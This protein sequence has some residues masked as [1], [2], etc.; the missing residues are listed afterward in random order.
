MISPSEQ[1]VL[2]IAVSITGIFRK[3]TYGLLGTYDGTPNNDLRNKNGSIVSSNA[4]LER[5]HNDFGMTW[6]I[7][8]S[9]SMFYY[10]S[11]QSA[12]FFQEQNRVFVPSFVDPTAEN[13]STI[14][15]VCEINATS[16]P[17]S[18]TVPGGPKVRK[19]SIFFGFYLI[20]RRLGLIFIPH[21]L[22]DISKRC[23]I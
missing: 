6:S 10:E 14:L 15:N 18:W 8:P 20:D 13:N 17:S 12:L 21:M 9:S 1:L 23:S 19:N 5:I 2:N 11:N 16:L 22:G 3:R 4:S 7:D